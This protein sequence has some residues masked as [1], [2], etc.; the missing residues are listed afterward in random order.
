MIAAS[1]KGCQG[2]HLVLVLFVIKASKVV[3]AKSRRDEIFIDV[4]QENNVSPFMGE[5]SDISLLRSYGLI[6]S[7]YKHFAATRL[8]RRA[9]S[10]VSSRRESLC[11]KELKRE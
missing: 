3:E 4:S 6:F 11:R 5:T 8:C 1:L 10:R 9:R 2:K 7:S